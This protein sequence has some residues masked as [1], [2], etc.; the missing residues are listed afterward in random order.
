MILLRKAV[1]LTLFSCLLPLAVR[2]ADDPPRPPGE[3]QLPIGL[4]EEEKTRLHEIGMLH[5]ATEPP[6]GE[7]RNPAEWEPSE[8][9]LVRWPLGISVALVAE[10]SEDVMVTTIVANA[11]QETDARSTYASGGVN[12]A[13]IDFIHASTDSIWVRDYGPWF[14]FNDSQLA[15][16]DHIYN[17]PRPQDDVIPQTIGTEW[18]LEVF[19]MDLTVSQQ[20][21]IVLLATLASIGSPGVPG[22]SIVM[23]IVVLTSVGIP[24]EALALILGVDRPIDMLRT[25]VNITGDSTVASIVAKS[26]GDL[27]YV[28]GQHA[29]PA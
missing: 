11:Q 20:L 7:V 27:G 19:G 22:G 10:M 8:G 15:I 23:L 4:T 12:L 14:I 6:A 18:G 5:R 2:S 21:S 28:P 9:V 24:V 3:P 13:N 29:D 26:E 25:V 16:V 17:R 1:C